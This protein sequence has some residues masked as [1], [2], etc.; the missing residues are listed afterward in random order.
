MPQEKRSC[1]R[2]QGLQLKWSHLPKREKGGRVV[3]QHGG[4][5]EV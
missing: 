1:G 4:E 3:Q 5:V 2:Q